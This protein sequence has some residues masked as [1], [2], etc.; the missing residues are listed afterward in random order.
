MLTRYGP[1]TRDHA[2][3]VPRITS[4][5]NTTYATIGQNPNVEELLSDVDEP[6]GGQT[7]PSY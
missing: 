1:G 6:G 4:P 2:S 5:K 3:P 7:Y